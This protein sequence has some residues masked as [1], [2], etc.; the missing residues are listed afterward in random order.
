MKIPENLVAADMQE[1]RAE[2]HSGLL[3]LGLSTARNYMMTETKSIQQGYGWS[4]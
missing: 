1:V 4:W 2:N 3:N